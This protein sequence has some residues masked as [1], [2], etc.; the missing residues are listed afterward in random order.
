MFL[1]LLFVTG[2]APHWARSDLEIA[3]FISRMRR[4]LA[5]ERAI[6]V[7]TERM[8]L[9]AESVV[10]ATSKITPFVPGNDLF[11]TAPL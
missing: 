2:D 10:L 6:T 1:A 8:T 9:V 7:S 11:W 3:G 4:A 5:V